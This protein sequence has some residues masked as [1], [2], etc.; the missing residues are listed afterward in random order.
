[1]Y[2]KKEGF[3]VKEAGNGRCF[4][5]DCSRKVGLIDPG[6]DDVSIH[7]NVL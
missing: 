7:D 2:L 4:G 1:M 5:P 6:F 3:Y